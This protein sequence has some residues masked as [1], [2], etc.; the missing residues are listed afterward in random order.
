M[1]NISI[2]LVITDPKFHNLYDRDNHWMRLHFYIQDRTYPAAYSSKQINWSNS[3]FKRFGFSH[4]PFIHFSID[5]GM[6]ISGAYAVTNRNDTILTDSWI[7]LNRQHEYLFVQSF[8]SIKTF[9]LL[10]R[11]K[12]TCLVEN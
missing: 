6:L 5:S 10:T 7:R 8:M 2:P 9:L 11:E 3:S 12:N 1:D 4:K